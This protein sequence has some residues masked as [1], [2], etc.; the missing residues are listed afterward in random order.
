MLT[1]EVILYLLQVM[2]LR[3]QLFHGHMISV[4]VW[5]EV[6]GLEGSNHSDRSLAYTFPCFPQKVGLMILKI[7]STLGDKLNLSQRQW[8][9][10]N[11]PWVGVHIC[12]ICDGRKIIRQGCSIFLSV[13]TSVS[14]RNVSPLM[15]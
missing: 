2:S 7:E 10:K 15:S 14:K 11:I 5:Q 9:K 12:G 3:I 13:V 4:M 8:Q 1:V 6:W